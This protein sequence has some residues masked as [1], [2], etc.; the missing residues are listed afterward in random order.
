[1]HSFRKVTLALVTACAL[2]SG[3]CQ[4]AQ[5]D[6]DAIERAY[7]NGQTQ[8]LTALANHHQ[9]Y[10]Q[11]LAQF[12]LSVAYSTH[13]QA[14]KAL[15]IVQGLIT[16]LEAH[17]KKQPDDDEALTL[18]AYAYSYTISLDQTVDAA[19]YAQ[20]SY[21]AL[22]KAASLAPDNPR[23]HLVQGILQYH[24]PTAYG[25]S[26]EAAKKFLQDALENYNHDVNSGVYWGHGEA[27]IWLGLTYLDLGNQRHALEHFQS[28]LALNPENGWAKYLVNINF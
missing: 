4:S 10:E 12:R 11:F 9:D 13:Q 25:G 26:K 7:M 20:Q 22:T 1:M 28:A 8:K 17:T 14:D 19:A 27:H 23:V 5:S 21:A 6:I 3:V 18:L 16:K 24:T 15:E 2:S